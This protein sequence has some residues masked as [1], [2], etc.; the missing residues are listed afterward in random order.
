MSCMM[1]KNKQKTS[2]MNKKSGALWIPASQSSMFLSK[3]YERKASNVEFC[4][5]YNEIY[6]LTLFSVFND[7]DASQKHNE[8]PFS[9]Q[10]ENIPVGCVPP[11]F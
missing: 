7:D 5:L 4:S 9:L 10:Q 3:I 2:S 8:L 11:A 1:L 6:I